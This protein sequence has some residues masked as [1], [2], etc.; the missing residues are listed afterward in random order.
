MTRRARV[1]GEGVQLHGS[2]REPPAPPRARGAGTEH[3]GRRR[4]HIA[5]FSC[6]CIGPSTVETVENRSSYSRWGARRGS[7]HRVRGGRTGTVATLI[8]EIGRVRGLRRATLTVMDALQLA[9]CMYIFTCCG[10]V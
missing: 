2:S 5:V 8:T 7:R 4:T 1:T 9:F 10:G 3:D 6:A